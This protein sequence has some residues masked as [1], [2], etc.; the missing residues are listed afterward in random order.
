[1][2]AGLGALGDNAVHTPVRQPLGQGHGGDHGEHLAAG[3]FPHGYVFAGVAGTGGDHG[4]VFFRHDPGHLGG[5][6]VHE[7]DVDAEGFVGPLPA[8][9]DLLAEDVGGHAAGAD[10]TQSTGVGYSGGKLA[11]GDVGH[12][13]LDNGELDPQHIV[14]T[15]SSYLFYSFS[16]APPQVRPAPKPTHRAIWPCRARPFS[17]SSSRAMG[18]LAAEVLP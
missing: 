15:H 10:K 5:L 17:S 4:D 7:H 14:E 3:C 12:A 1:M 2:A 9:V 6:G 13:A 16:S 11:G 8:D 18:M